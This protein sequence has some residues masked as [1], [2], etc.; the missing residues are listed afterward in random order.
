MTCLSLWPEL[1]RL[2]E[3]AGLVVTGPHPHNAV[4]HEARVF[5]GRD[6][7]LVVQAY[8]ADRD[9]TMREQL[10]AAIAAERDRATARRVREAARKEADRG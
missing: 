9:E 8:G 4:S 7:R 1:R 5:R 10:A 6:L 3:I 2:A